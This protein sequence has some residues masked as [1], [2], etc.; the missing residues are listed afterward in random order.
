V[1]SVIINKF[2]DLDKQVDCSL[3][4]LLGEVLNDMLEEFDFLV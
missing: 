2:K 1:E 3:V 4:V